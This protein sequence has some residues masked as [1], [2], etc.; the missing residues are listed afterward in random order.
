MNTA[1]NTKYLYYLKEKGLGLLLDCKKDD[2]IILYASF[3]I[4]F[5]ALYGVVH[6]ILF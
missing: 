6:H 3:I 1:L 4:H 5:A 2:V